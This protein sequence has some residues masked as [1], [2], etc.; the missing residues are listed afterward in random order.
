MV[1]ASSPDPDSAPVALDASTPRLSREAGPARL[2]V[3]GAPFFVRGVELHNSA[4]SAGLHAKLQ[5]AKDLNANTVLASVTWEEIEPREG[6]FD[7]S[8]VTA[9]IDAARAADVR[10]VLLWFGAWKNGSSSY[11]P[12]WVRQDWNRFERCVLSDGTMTETLSPFGST[13]LD[14]DAFMAVVQHVERI[15]GIE[16]TVLMVQVENEVGLLGASRD[17]SAVAETAFAAPVPAPVRAALGGGDDAAIQWADLLDGGSDRDEAFMAWGLST[18]IELLAHSARSRTALPFFVNAWLDSEIDIDVPGFAIAGGK[19]PGTYPSGGPI[20]RVAAVWDHCA[21]SIDLRA[22]DYYFGAPE[23]VFG[24]FLRTA[25]GLFIPEMRRDAIGVG[26]IFQAVGSY[27]ALGT[28]PFGVDSADAAELA[29]LADGYGILREIETSLTDQHGASRPSV[30]FAL[31]A[32]TPTLTA[33]LG[34]LELHLSRYAGIA[35]EPA[36]DVSYGLVIRIGPDQFI[37]AGRGFRLGFATEG[38][39]ERIAI[40]GAREL[41]REDLPELAP[42]RR[43]NGD[44]TAGGAAILHPPLEHP[45]MSP[46]PIPAQH[47]H[48]GLTEVSVYRYPARADR[49]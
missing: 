44:E 8:S 15:D 23:V 42:R 46:F 27:Q 25:R 45:G 11:A 3:D 49:D 17:R 47:R 28:S 34:G 22:P 26:H 2:V 36:G 40:A 41:G 13:D 12:L 38:G 1:L 32:K 30:G 37:V 29:P 18:R 19:G 4:S 21:P 43:L 16:R 24:D 9:M 7:L 39:A 31:T 5:L 20:P 10:L 48:T 33:R 6:E 35:L 14:L